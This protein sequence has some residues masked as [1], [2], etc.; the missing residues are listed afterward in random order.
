ML[1]TQWQHIKL[2]SSRALSN[3]VT[4]EIASFGHSYEIKKE[5]L[6]TL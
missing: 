3:G 2:R 4:S 1:P 6:F 5:T